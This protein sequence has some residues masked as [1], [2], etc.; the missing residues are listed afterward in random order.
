MS[1]LRILHLAVFSVLLFGCSMF[2]GLGSNAVPPMLI[3]KTA[4]PP[5]PS[6]LASKTFDLK[7]DLIISRT[8]SVVRAE[9]L[10]SSGDPKWDSMAVRNIMNWKY[11]PATLN[12]KPIQMRISQVA[13]VIYAPP[14]TMILSQIVCTTAEEADSVF[15]ALQNGKSFDSL[16]SEISPTGSV[17][18]S[19]YLGEVD[20]RQYSEEI[21]KELQKLQ[22]NSYTP[23][24]RLGIYYAIFMRHQYA[25]IEA[26]PR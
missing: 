7:T 6:N 22:V 2:G 25:R 24:L 5:L 11:S 3:Q 8:G 14:L 13:H 16:V 12:G 17:I 1:G 20:I 26:L 15:N 19:G 18:N 23:P 9:L 10:N 4:F 21:Q